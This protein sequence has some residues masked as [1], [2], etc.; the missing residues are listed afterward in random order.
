MADYIITGNPT[1]FGPGLRMSDE[2]L[3]P[4]AQVKDA[5]PAIADAADGLQVLVTTTKSLYQATA[6]STSTNHLEFSFTP[7]TL[8]GF[9]GRIGAHR[10]IGTVNATGTMPTGLP[11]S[12]VGISYS[13]G[14]V[15]SIWA[16][17]QVVAAGAGFALHYGNSLYNLSYTGSTV[18]YGGVS[19][20]LYTERITDAEFA[21]P[22]FV[23]NTARTYSLSAPTAIFTQAS[24][25]HWRKVTDFDAAD[26]TGVTLGDN[27]GLT[28]RGTPGS[29]L[30]NDRQFTADDKDKLNNL[31][32]RGRLLWETTITNGDSTAGQWGQ[33]ASGRGVGNPPPGDTDTAF[34]EFSNDQIP[35]G[36]STVTAY[37]L[38]RNAEG[39]LEFWVHGD[40]DWQTYYFETP[41]GTQYHFGSA[42]LLNTTDTGGV[43]AIRTWRSVPA[44]VFAGATTVMKL[45]RPYADDAYLPPG[46]T[47][48]Q[49]IHRT[50][51]GADWE[52]YTPEPDLLTALP[53]A[54]D[55]G[56][57]VRYSGVA[58]YPVTVEATVTNP[59]TGSYIVGFD[60]QTAGGLTLQQLNYYTSDYNG[61]EAVARRN[62]VFATYQQ[63]DN[64]TADAAILVN[65]TR[66]A[67]ATAY[68]NA[69]ADHEHAIA[70]LKTTDFAVGTTYRIQFV[71]AAV[72][73]PADKSIG[74]AGVINE[75]E[76]SA[77][78][79]WV[80]AGSAPLNSDGDVPLTSLPFVTLTQAAYDALAAGSN[81]D[82]GKWY[83]TTA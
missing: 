70:S 4:W 17:S 30:V 44:S 67:I 77:V 46:G 76:Y 78:D 49:I 39:E 53:Y 62:K 83:L 9:P 80:Y 28:G 50:A 59:T 74:H 55:I 79:T 8:T 56:T 31:K 22:P 5:L 41:D 45:Y 15:I 27:P 51:T 1:P 12:I 14:G 40:H 57:K 58:T 2:W 72:K 37:A 19:I 21:S 26:F 61:P 81:L 69:A 68:L 65:N 23:V 33:G 54:P 42:E 66:H 16:T 6:A 82:S 36:G 10:T 13:V 7:V 38:W 3:S 71:V 43:E 25:R 73:S 52:D 34:G 48:G 47:T 60:D 32:H 29:P 64:T 35:D 20:Y 18:T 75:F 63:V 11:S 24:A